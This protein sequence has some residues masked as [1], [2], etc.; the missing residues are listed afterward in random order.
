MRRPS[1][2][3]RRRAKRA[4]LAATLC[5][6]SG[7]VLSCLYWPSFWWKPSDS[8][9]KWRIHITPDAVSLNLSLTDFYEREKPSYGGYM[10]TLAQQRYTDHPWRP[11][12]VWAPKIEIVRPLPSNSPGVTMPLW[13]PLLVCAM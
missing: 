1:I 3:T 8:L 13:M 10:R 12:F 11:P 4:W 7:I 2:M 5:V 6:G 9:R